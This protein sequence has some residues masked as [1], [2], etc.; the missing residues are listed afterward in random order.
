M[1]VEHRPWG[2]FEVL[3]EDSKCVVK[4]ITIYPRSRLSLQYHG[5]RDETWICTH[6][7][8]RVYGDKYNL[9]DGYPLGYGESITIK[10]GHTHRAF[11]PLKENSTFIEIQTGDKLSE[12]DIIRFE[13]D[14]GRA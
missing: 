9:V 5:Y 1:K 11:N 12:D 13:D 8:I 3:Y 10:K 4:K 7:H 6:G 2:Q 14:Y